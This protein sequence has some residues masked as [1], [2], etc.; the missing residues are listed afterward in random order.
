MSASALLRLIDT[1][2]CGLRKSKTDKRSEE[3]EIEETQ[4][5]LK[6]DDLD[7]EVESL[8]CAWAQGP[9]LQVEAYDDWGLQVVDRIQDDGDVRGERRLKEER[10]IQDD[11]AVRDDGGGQDNTELLVLEDDEERHN[12]TAKA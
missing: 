2:C 7:S 5:L 1:S 3:R 10:V 8:D 12:R 11:G 9:L 4:G 6:H